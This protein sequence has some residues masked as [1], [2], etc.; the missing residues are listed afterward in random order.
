MAGRARSPEEEAM[1]HNMAATWESLAE[2]RKAHI[3]PQKRVAE[4]ENGVAGSIPVDRLNA[5]N[6]D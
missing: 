2:D 5:S 1:L 4:L 6:D 3:A